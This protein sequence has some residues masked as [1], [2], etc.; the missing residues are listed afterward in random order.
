MKVNP[1]D[2]VPAFD[3]VGQILQQALNFQESGR[4]QLA[5]SLYRT[6]LEAD[7][8]HA[9]AN[10]RLGQMAVQ[11]SQAAGGLTYFA[12]ALEAEPTEQR[13]WLGYINA[14]ICANESD[15]A[16]Q[17]LA[18][19]RQHGLQ[20]EVVE[21]LAVQLE[22]GARPTS[23]V[24]ETKP[25]IEKARVPAVPHVDIG[26]ARKASPHPRGAGKGAL[27]APGEVNKLLALFKQRRFTEAKAFAQSL[28]TRFPRHGFGWKLLGAVIEAQGNLVEAL[29]PMQTAAGF[30]PDDPQ[31]HENLGRVLQALGRLAEAE[32][33]Y[34]RAIEV[35]PKSVNGYINLGNL[36]HERGQFA[37]A[38]ANYRRALDIDPDFG[39]AHTNLGRTV[40]AQGRL[41]EAEA[42]FR[43]AVQCQPNNA[44][45]LSNLLF[46]CSLSEAVDA[47]S[48]FTEH[49]RFGQL[50][51]APLHARWRQHSNT[52]DPDRTLRIGFVSGDFR[53]HAAAFF[54][55]PMFEYLAPHANLSLHAYANYPTEDAVTQRLQ[56]HVEHWHKI[57]GLSDLA[58]A[59]K[60]RADGIDIL[61]DLS[62]HSAHNRLLSFAHKPTPVQVGWMGYPGT[63][64]LMGMDYYLGDRFLLPPGKFDHLFTEKLVHLPA[65]ATFLP[66]K[67]APPV[68]DLPALRNGQVTFGSFNRPNKISRDVIA[69]WSQL[70]RALPTATMVLG[71][72]P[73]AG[74][75]D[76]LLNWFTEESIAL[77]RLRFYPKTNMQ[78]YLAL[79]HQIDFCLDTFPFNGGITTMHALWMGVPTLA[80]A[81]ATVG[82]RMG[83][84]I[85]GHVALDE[86]V[87]PDAES[88]VQRG[89]SWAQRL[90]ELAS[91]RASLRQRFAQSAL[92]LPALAGAGLE[93]A[94]RTM[95]RRWC[96]NL[97][98]AT[99]EVRA[100]DLCSTA[101]EAI[102]E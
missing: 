69:L 102:G 55:E 22:G 4:I 94:L 85:L 89:L 33:C 50:F 78:G 21:A 11:A 96:A 34:R 61:I 70:L 41:K 56:K 42:C 57:A 17:L 97:P 58:V 47:A 35:A 37:D 74:Q 95:W 79:H 44:A 36:Q 77:E 91:L 81:G 68:N 18:L 65:Y 39:N 45:L 87:A 72:F 12:T 92:G 90:P 15:T 71:G 25:T 43:R 59:E 67:L 86:F 99:F 46:C 7:A 66:S 80:L 32:A 60:I 64:G 49:C 63:T 27:P 16:R 84:G 75:Y 30:W 6:I 54:I 26:H 19:G 31:T 29:L 3:A 88:F 8:Q 24:P 28:T 9:E 48:L 38:E 62:G 23:P 52:R 76:T 93:Q 83:A 1:V 20:G 82:G 40:H 10:F 53:N 73:P 14:L 101:P 13:Y 51:E 2:E 98:A 100:V 5:E